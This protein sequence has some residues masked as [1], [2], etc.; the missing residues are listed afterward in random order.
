MP[1]ATQGFHCVSWQSS[2]CPRQPLGAVS[3]SDNDDKSLV[4]SDLIKACC[5]SSSHTWTWS[6][7]LVLWLIA[8]RTVTQHSMPVTVS[9]A[10]WKWCVWDHSVWQS[11]CQTVNI[12]V[13]ANLYFDLQKLQDSGPSAWAWVLGPVHSLE[14]PGSPAFRRNNDKYMPTAH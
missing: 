13:H 11:L 4:K 9:P 12:H 6:K 10:P 2:T 1:A 8:A 14:A 7:S 3:V 5:I